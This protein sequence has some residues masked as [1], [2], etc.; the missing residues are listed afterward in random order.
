MKPLVRN[1]IRGYVVLCAVILWSG[2]QTPVGVQRTSPARAYGQIEANI[3]SSGELSPG[4]QAVL[5]RSI[6]QNASP[7]T[8]SP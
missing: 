3:L 5:R 7:T 8:R 4:T 1:I 2:C 6:Q